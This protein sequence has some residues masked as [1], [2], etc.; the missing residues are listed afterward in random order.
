MSRVEGKGYADTGRSGNEGE[1]REGHP[2]IILVPCP[3]ASLVDFAST[4]GSVCASEQDQRSADRCDGNIKGEIGRQ[5]HREV[6]VQVTG[7][8]TQAN[9][10]GLCC[11]YIPLPT[12]GLDMSPGNCLLVNRS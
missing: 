8:T 3:V 5:R 6:V 4:K 10:E 1:K 2:D 9:R 12:R 7:V 11:N